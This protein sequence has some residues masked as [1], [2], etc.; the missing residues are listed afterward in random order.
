MLVK[1]LLLAEGYQ[2]A[3]DQRASNAL[4]HDRAGGWRILA[5][6][7]KPAFQALDRL[8]GPR[9]RLRFANQARER[10]TFSE[11]PQSISRRLTQRRLSHMISL[12]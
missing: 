7:H 10:I 6:R 2:L 3:L 12:S 8:A 4:V 1:L 11:Q 5:R 9:Q